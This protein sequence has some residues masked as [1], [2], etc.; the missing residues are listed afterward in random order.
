MSLSFG[1]LKTLLLTFG[2]ETKLKAFKS[3][4]IYR[5]WKILFMN[6]NQDF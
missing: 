5:I 1:S 2:F 3:F 4:A 6:T